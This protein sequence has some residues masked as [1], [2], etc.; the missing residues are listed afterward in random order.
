MPSDS[1]I[2]AFLKEA[3][4]RLILKMVAAL[5]KFVLVRVQGKV[6]KVPAFDKESESSKLA[7]HFMVYDSEVPMQAADCVFIGKPAHVPFLG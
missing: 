3:T 2:D 1:E 4:Q 6:P 7:E 5:L